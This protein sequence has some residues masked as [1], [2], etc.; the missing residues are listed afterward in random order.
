LWENFL[1]PR[2]RP[3]QYPRLINFEEAAIK[4][5]ASLTQEKEFIMDN[6]LLSEDM[7]PQVQQY[8]VTVDLFVNALSEK[9]AEDFVKQVLQQTFTSLGLE[10]QQI[11]SVD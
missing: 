2:Q 6:A 3:L 5:P 7:S 9:D 4:K 11:Q 8:K 1:R 10:Q